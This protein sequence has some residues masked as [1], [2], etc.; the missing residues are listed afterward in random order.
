[1][2]CTLYLWVSVLF[3]LVSPLLASPSPTSS[4]PWTLGLAPARP[5][6]PLAQ[7]LLGTVTHMAYPHLAHSPCHALSYHVARS[8]LCHAAFVPHRPSTSALPRTAQQCLPY[9]L[10]HRCTPLLYST[11]CLVP[12]NPF[13]CHVLTVYKPMLCLWHQPR[14]EL[15]EQLSYL[16]IS[17]HSR[18]ISLQVRL[19][20]VLCN[21]S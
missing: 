6:P 15:V 16:F 11:H 12:Y 21:A 2:L 19:A 5:Y 8:A 1:M 4:H 13:H 17:L 10:P 7:P 14:F 3:V 9:P 18:A 20:L